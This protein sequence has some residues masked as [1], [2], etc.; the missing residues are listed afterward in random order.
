MNI[1]KTENRKKGGRLNSV[2]VFWKNDRPG[3]AGLIFPSKEGLDLNATIDK[4]IINMEAGLASNPDK[5]AFVAGLENLLYTFGK[6]SE[7]NRPQ[8]AGMFFGG[9]YML[10]KLG[11][12]VNDEFNGIVYY[13]EE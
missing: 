11:R 2:H 8:F 13:Y 12:L 7:G 10:L 5:E 6:L 1:T 4:L 3:G 9:V